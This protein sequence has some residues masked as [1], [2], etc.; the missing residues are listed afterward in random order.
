MVSI[1]KHYHPIAWL[2]LGKGI[3]GVGLSAVDQRVIQLSGRL[4]FNFPPSADISNSCVAGATLFLVED[5][6]GSDS[7]ETPKAF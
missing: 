5:F 1:H 4:S 3:A 6:G 7:F 2:P